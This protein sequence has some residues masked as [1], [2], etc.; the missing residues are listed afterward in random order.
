MITSSGLPL[1]ANSTA[2]LRPEI[3][4]G[5]SVYVPLSISTA[6]IAPPLALMSVIACASGHFIASVHTVPLPLDATY[7]MF[8]LDKHEPF[9]RQTPPAQSTL[10]MQP[11][12]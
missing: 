5:P 6:S 1:V 7:R 4:Y 8:E 10:V 2:L 11:W 9:G 3:V 12:H